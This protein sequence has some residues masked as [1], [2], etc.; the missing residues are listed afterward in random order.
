MGDATL[1]G[2]IARGDLRWGPQLVGPRRHPLLYPF[3]PFGALKRPVFVAEA[4]VQKL[5][6]IFKSQARE[7]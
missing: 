3:L 6:K 1:R 2:G 5:R 4:D 7:A